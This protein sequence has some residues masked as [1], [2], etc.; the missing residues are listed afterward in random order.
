MALPWLIG[1]AVVALGAAAVSAFSD[2]S[3]SGSGGNG[4]EE[5]RRRER[6]EQER[7]ARAHKEKLESM[8]EAF[9]Q[10]GMQR[11]NDLQQSL[12]GQIK[13]ILLGDK[14]FKAILDN[15]E[16]FSDL[17]SPTYVEVYDLQFLPQETQGYLV[18]LESLYHVKLE[19]EEELM[20]VPVRLKEIDH[21]LAQLKALRE[22]FKSL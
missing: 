10:E 17:V 15:D 13:V 6:A 20:K 1:A 19:P 18:K 5:R 12:E 3:D 14:P 2:D 8:K 21:K 11:A 7:K 22:S 9:V 16:D 4:D